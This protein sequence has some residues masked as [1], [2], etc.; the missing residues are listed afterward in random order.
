MDGLSHQFFAGAAFAAD[1]NGGVGLG[2][3]LAEFFQRIHFVIFRMDIVK[4]IFSPVHESDFAAVCP[5]AVFHL[6]DPLIQF[7]QLFGVFEN[8][9]AGGADDLPLMHQRDPVG[10]Y[11]G[12]VYFLKLK[13]FFF[14]GFGNNMQSGIFQHFSYRF[15]KD[16]TGS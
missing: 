10:D 11:I 7:A 8:N 12:P 13:K 5:E 15:P 4:G 3:D 2:D 14:S 16:V 6:F 9:G 1:Q